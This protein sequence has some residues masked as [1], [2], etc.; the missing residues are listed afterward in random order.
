M[1]MFYAFFIYGLLPLYK[2]IAPYESQIFYWSGWIQLWALPLLM[3][4]GIVSAKIQ[5]QKNQ[6]RE[7]QRQEDHAHITSALAEIKK[8][9]EEL[10]ATTLEVHR[11]LRGERAND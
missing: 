4:G 7:E 10:H 8:T 9:H 5:E 3:V 11:I 1:W 6:E 2:P